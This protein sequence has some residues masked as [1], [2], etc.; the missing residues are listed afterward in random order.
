MELKIH[1]LLPLY[2]YLLGIEPWVNTYTQP[3]LIGNDIRNEWKSIFLQRQEHPDCVCLWV[4]H[5]AEVFG[6]T[7]SQFQ[8]FIL[9][10]HNRKGQHTVCLHIVYVFPK[11]K[12]DCCHFHLRSAEIQGT[13]QWKDR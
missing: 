12:K 13:Q 5:G 6:L 8:V 7:L 9:V 3:Q 10:L 1:A 11:K 4:T 2:K